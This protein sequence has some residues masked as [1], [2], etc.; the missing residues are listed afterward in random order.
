MAL[1]IMCGKSKPRQNDGQRT[2]LSGLAESC[3]RNVG[4]PQDV[5][6]LFL[7]DEIAPDTRFQSV[8]EEVKVLNAKNLTLSVATPQSKQ[9]A[10][11]PT[12][13]PDA[14]STLRTGLLRSLFCC[15]RIE[16][17]DKPLATGAGAGSSSVGSAGSAGFSDSTWIGV[18][19][20][21][22]SRPLLLNKDGGINKGRCEWYLYLPDSPIDLRRVLA[23]A[24]TLLNTGLWMRI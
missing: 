23:D 13:E 18:Y 16:G 2:G 11:G 21:N 4:K 22:N 8:P 14:E 20:K 3:S 7:D 10:D 15:L 9:S 5:L 17:A 6:Q 24:G 12:G 1:F 19:R